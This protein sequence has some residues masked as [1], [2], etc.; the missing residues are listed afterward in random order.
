[1]EL[2]A[3]KEELEKNRVKIVR[4]ETEKKST[5]AANLRLRSEND[6]IA[7]ERDRYVKLADSIRRIESGLESRAH[8]M[9]EQLKQD[10]KRLESELQSERSSV[11]TLREKH[12]EEIGSLRSSEQGLNERLFTLQHKHDLLEQKQVSFTERMK[13]LENQLARKEEELSSAQEDLKRQARS[14]VRE[15]LVLALRMAMPATMEKLLWPLLM[16]L[17]SSSFKLPIYAPN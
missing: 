5:D 15:A 12:A 17:P 1:M 16:K 6:Q 4:M 14:I 2:N 13:G 9:N 8:D 11:T 10:V 7:A 3:A